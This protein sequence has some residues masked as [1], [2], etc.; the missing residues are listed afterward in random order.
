MAPIHDCNRFLTAE[1]AKPASPCARY[2]ILHK[3]VVGIALLV[4]LA[5]SLSAACAKSFDRS[6]KLFTADLKKYV[7]GSL[8]HY[9]RWQKHQGN[10][11][12]YLK[13]VADLDP[14]VLEAFSPKEK[15]AFWLNVYN[16]ATVK[17]VLD[18]YPIQ[19]TTKFY[20]SHS[21]RQIPDVWEKSHFTV[22]GHDYTLDQIE[23]DILRKD[24]SDPRLHFAA[25][26]ATRDC[27]PLLKRAYTGENID[28][29]LHALTDRF[30]QDKDNID[31][32]FSK[33]T[34]QVSKI[35]NWFPLDFSKPAGFDKLKFPP[36]KDEDI[37]LAY[38]YRH[39]APDVKERLADPSVRAEY[40]VSYKEYDWTLNDADQ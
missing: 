40:K 2:V 32:D 10:L 19:D 11:D 23:H 37:I 20:P 29:E 34:V 22:A 14:A 25:C 13:S 38:I 15:K 5:F 26:C 39:A 33:K 8:V 36:P 35:F 16:A 21:L 7:D 4:L 18:H 9:K 30:M 31:F 12:K 28:R 17:V 6:H 3:R 24:F 27:A 1:K